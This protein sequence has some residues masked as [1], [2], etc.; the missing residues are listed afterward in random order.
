[1]KKLLLK[2]VIS[3]CTVCWLNTTAQNQNPK[4][5]AETQNA[6]NPEKVTCAFSF[7]DVTVDSIEGCSGPFAPY[8]LTVHYTGTCPN[9]TMQIKYNDMNGNDAYMPFNKSGNDFSINVVNDATGQDLVLIGTDGNSSDSML[10]ELYTIPCEV[11]I[12]Y[13]VLYTNCGA[14]IYSNFSSN[15]CWPLDNYF[16]LKKLNSNTEIINTTSSSIYSV[17][18]GTYRIEIH[19]IGGCST[20]WDTIVIAGPDRAAPTN[21]SAVQVGSQNKVKIKWED[22]CG[23]SD[24]PLD[25]FQIKYR[26]KGNN[27]WSFKIITHPKNTNS[28][29][30][31]Y[32]K[33]DNIILNTVY[34]YRI[35]STVLDDKSLWSPI[36]EFCIG[37]GC[38]ARTVSETDVDE[39]NDAIA[40]FPNPAKD[41]IH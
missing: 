4:T 20:G 21:L 34:E 32:T 11:S 26:I 27:T 10:F 29:D 12:S 23:Y 25:F 5:I 19:D 40:V 13:N 17:P 9:V 18:N 24:I 33:I 2:T 39:S 8:T 3:L 14:N 28:W 31:Y 38:A 35:S 30:K 15:F 1:M 37:G 41:V 22:N 7:N 36:H 6:A 16:R